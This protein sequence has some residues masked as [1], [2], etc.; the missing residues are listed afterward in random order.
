MTKS[1]SS[2]KHQSTTIAQNRR[3]K[4]DFHIE[5]EYEAGLVLHGW[6]V[7]SL[8]AGKAQLTDSYVRIL[9]SEAWLIGARISPLTTASTH[10]KLDDTRSRKVL[11]HRREIAQLTGLIERKGYTLVAIMLYW[12]MGKCKLKLGIAKGKKQYD[13]RETIKQ[14]EWQRNEGRQLKNTQQG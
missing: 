12:K 5:K 7:K 4:F 13:K 6:E 10:Q 3:A 1:A 11:L 8:R 14:R 2:N 9:K